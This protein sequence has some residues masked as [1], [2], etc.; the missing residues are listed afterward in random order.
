M[1]KIDT[2]VLAVTPQ[3]VSDFLPEPILSGMRSLARTFLVLDPSA[4]GPDAFF[5]ELA[6]ADPEVL[7]TCWSIHPLPARLPPR[8]RYVC[9]ITGGVRTLLTRSHLEGGLILTNWGGSISRTVAECALLLTLAALRRAGHWVHAMHGSGAWRDD[10]PEGESLFCQRVGLHGFGQVA[11]E[12]IKLA[13]PF[14]VEV[15]V[16]A[17][18]TDPALYA[19]HRVRRVPTLEELFGGHDVVVEVAPLTPATTGLVTERLLRLIRPGGVFVNVGR[20]KV[21]DEAALLRVAR[22]GRIQVG[23]DVYCVEPLPA[24]SGFRGLPNVVLLPHIAGPTLERRR[25]AGAF[26]LRNLRAYAGEG[27]LE[28]VITPA[29]FDNAP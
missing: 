14:G 5:R 17:P 25:D 7:V 1:T 2:L 27:T 6:A 13:A 10:R 9:H 3:E 11:R 21:V 29:I 16:C 28:A 22:E 18:E 15:G 20:G 12:F 4:L 23:L 24:D 19:A 26:A 8:L